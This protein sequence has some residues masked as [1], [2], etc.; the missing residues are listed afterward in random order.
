MFFWFGITFFVFSL[1]RQAGKTPF[2]GGDKE[3][4]GVIELKGIITDAEETLDHILQFRLSKSIKAIVV[5]IDC[6]GGAVGAS[7]EIFRE[8][9][10]ANEVK[11]VVA[12]MG[13]VAASGGYYAA[14][15]AGKIV[16]SPG[17]LTG[18]MGV[19][20]KFPNL[21][22]IFQKIGYRDEVIKSGKL[23]D[24]GSPSRP[25][26]TEERELLQSLLDEVHEQFIADI[27]QSRKLPSDDV[28]KVADG[29]I[30]SGETAKNLG[31]VDEL[32]NFNDAVSLAAKL[33]GLQTE[34][35]LLVYPEEDQLSLL[36]MLAEQNV[37]SLLRKVTSHSPALYFE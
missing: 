3:S 12:S 15:G 8:I 25:L 10:R 35:P 33:A 9:A 20:F 24:I 14:I 31:L 29:R 4:V 1:N 22:E 36:K 19:I 23:K 34:T 5:R 37:G 21:E 7:Q 27:A 13:S 11:P 28:R 2:L 17:T 16:A 18:S 32:G 30:F 6:P 26:T